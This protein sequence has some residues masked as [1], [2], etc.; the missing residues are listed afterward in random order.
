VSNPLGPIPPR[1]TDFEDRAQNNLPVFLDPA[2]KFEC[3]TAK[4]IHNCLLA[5]L[6]AASAADCRLS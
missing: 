3:R 1:R 5:L 4:V 2:E 6:R